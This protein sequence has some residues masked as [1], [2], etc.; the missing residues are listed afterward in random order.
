MKNSN[1][2]LLMAIIIT[3]LISGAEASGPPTPPSEAYHS[4]K[5]RE[6]CH[7]QPKDVY[8]FGALLNTANQKM[9]CSK[10]ND[11]QRKQAMQMANQKNAFGN[12][13][14][15]PDEAVEKVAA[16]NKLTSPTKWWP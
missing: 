3:A 12:P 10:F 6:Q 15:T 7:A 14:M 16:E 1:M 5:M 9:F 8:N 2:T 4:E 11:A 13:S